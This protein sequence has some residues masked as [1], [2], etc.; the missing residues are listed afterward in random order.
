[1]DIKDLE[2]VGMDPNRC[3]HKLRPATLRISFFQK[4]NEKWQ[5]VPK[6]SQNILPFSSIIGQIYT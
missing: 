6:K 3:H 2:S 1:M 4:E 5:M